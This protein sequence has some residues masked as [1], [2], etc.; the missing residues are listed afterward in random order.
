MWWGEGAY[1]QVENWPHLQ[2]SSQVIS[3]A[4]MYRGQTCLLCLENTLYLENF[5]TLCV[6]VHLC[7]QRVHLWGVHYMYVCIRHGYVCVCI[8]ICVCVCI[9]VHVCTRM[10]ACVHIYSLCLMRKEVCSI[11]PGPGDNLIS[12]GLLVLHAELWKWQRLSKSE[13]QSSSFSGFAMI[14]WF[15]KWLMAKGS[16]RQHLPPAGSAWPGGD[17][18]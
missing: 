14:R 2:S 1:V 15:L 17:L 13:I 8:C 6:C 3:H 18:R 12:P 16:E 10:F 4:S 7:A 11:A 9:H 5:W